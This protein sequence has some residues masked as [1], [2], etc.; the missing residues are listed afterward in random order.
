MLRKAVSFQNYSASGLHYIGHGMD[1]K[2]P[3][4]AIGGT[5]VIVNL[6]L[7]T[8]TAIKAAV[9]LKRP[10]MQMTDGEI[11]EDGVY[12]DYMPFQKDNYGATATPGASN[13]TTEGY[14]VGSVWVNTTATPHEVYRC[15]DASEGRAVWLNTSLEISEVHVQGTDQGLDT[16][17]TNAVTAAQAKGAVTNSHASGS[18]NQ[19]LAALA[20]KVPADPVPTGKVAAFD[21]TGNLVVPTPDA[22]IAN[23][24]AVSGTSTN[25][26]YGFVSAEEMGTFITNVNAMK[27]AVNAVLS[28]LEGRGLN[29]AS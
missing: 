8:A 1:F 14:S 6:P 4:G 19:S 2:V 25:G 23:A 22:H 3:G 13:D 12:P 10:A 11:F 9:L 26:G 7:E 28:R 27:D 29:A 21:A 16:G 24:T 18:D 20:T 17:G 15:V 5:A